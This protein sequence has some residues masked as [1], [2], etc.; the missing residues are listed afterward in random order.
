MGRSEGEGRTLS[1]RN[2]FKDNVSENSGIENFVFKVAQ[3]KYFSSIN[4][5]VKLFFFQSGLRF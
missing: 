1:N 2:R 3:K 4:L 5:R